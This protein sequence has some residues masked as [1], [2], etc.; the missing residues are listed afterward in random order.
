VTEGGKPVTARTEAGSYVVEA[1][2]GTYD[3]Q[4]K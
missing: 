1:G 2:S 4:V 3:F